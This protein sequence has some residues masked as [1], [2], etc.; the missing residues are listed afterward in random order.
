MDYSNRKSSFAALSALLALC[1]IWQ[2]CKNDSPKAPLASQFAPDPE[3]AAL[4]ERLAQS[5][6]NDSLYYRRAA[7]Y[8]ALNGYDEALS[9]VAKA[10]RL[11]SMKAPYYHLMADILLDYA[12]PNDSRRAIEVLK[13]ASTVFP[14]DIHTLLKLSEFQLIVKQHSEALSA[15]SRI[16]QKDPQNAE[17]YYMT[18]RIALDMGDTLRSTSSLQRAVQI[19]P[20]H[21][22]AWMFLG[23]I[24]TNQNNPKAIQC[25]DNVLAIDSTSLEARE[26]KGVFY[27]R[28]GA[29]NQAFTV[30]RD[31][32]KRNPDYSNA[33]FDMAMIY[34]E[35]DSL[36]QAY[37]HFDVAIKTDPLFVKAYYYRGVTLEAKGSI[38]AAVADYTQANKMAPNFPEPKE[39][40]ARLGKKAVK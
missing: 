27:K 39:A 19:N 20:D 32:I 28:K 3:I 35:L 12:R 9:D 6:D 33:F 7:A 29:F 26:Y 5:P 1:L 25:F 24:Y 23:R 18:G 13:K 8:Y 22:D 16:L 4:S 36:D 38:E 2:A 40:L 10:I 17:A 34:L 15:I 11:D 37:D 21:S 30:Y 14:D 31:I